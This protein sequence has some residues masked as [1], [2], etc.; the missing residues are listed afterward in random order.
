MPVIGQSE[1]LLTVTSPLGADALLATGFRGREELSRPFAFDLDL[2]S[3]NAALAAADLVGQPVGWAVNRPAD[4]PRHFHGYVKRLVAGPRLSRGLRSYRVEVVPWLWFLTRTADCRIFQNQT[5]PDIVKAVFA[6]YGFTAYR[7]ALTATYPTR[8]YVVQYRESAFDFVSRLLEEYGIYYYFEFADGSHTLVLADAAS[9][10]AAPGITAE[11]RPGAGQVVAVTRWDRAYQFHTGKATHTDY[12]FTTP[13]TALLAQEPTTVTLPGISKFEQFDYPG[14]YAAG[15]D[16]KALVKVRIEA[17]EATHD[18]AAGAG[19]IPGFAAGAKFTLAGHP[20]DDGEYALTAVGHE[21]TEEWVAGTKGGD[22][23]YTN[24]FACVPAATP[25]RPARLTPRPVV[26][27][28]Q[29]AVVVGPGGEEIHTDRYGR[30]K[31]QFFWDRVGTHDENSSCWIRV[32]GVWAGR[33]WGMIFT[34]R[35]G[36]EVMVEFLEGDPDQPVVTG[37]VYNAD[38]MPPYALPDNMT[39]SGL[40]TRSTKQGGAADFNELRFEDKKGGEDVYF[41][42]QKDFHRFVENDDDLKVE[43]DQTITVKNNRTLV[44]TEGYEK[45]TIEKGDRERTVS[46]GNDTLT[47]SG[48]KRTVTVKADTAL[49]VEEGNHTVTVSKGTQ[50]VEVKADTTLTVQEGSYTV[51]VSKGKVTVDAKEKITLV[52]GSNSI[53]IDTS[54]VVIDAQKISLKVGGNLVELASAGVELKGATVKVA[55]D[56]EAKFEGLTTVVAGSG[57]LELKGGIVKIN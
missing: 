19:G 47:V 51:T 6:R 5:I 54:G 23:T 2:V 41:H 13:A 22:A 25:F 12:N 55:A 26:P 40:K 14:R 50:T 16:G 46:K 8:E 9:G 52:V 39:Q 24:T 32:A 15:A 53:V 21:A 28:P 10:Y 45:V 37:R 33:Q 3:E 57:Q 7:D 27:G 44:V 31:V 49:T 35:I 29:P 48:G 20:A 34:P 56:T 38:Q 1:R 43:H 42:A 11:Y 18:T 30:V 17:E 36:Q 4:A